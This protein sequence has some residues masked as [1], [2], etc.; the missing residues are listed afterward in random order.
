MSQGPLG[1][2]LWLICLLL[3]LWSV[4]EGARQAGAELIVEYGNTIQILTLIF[5]AVLGAMVHDVT[6]GNP[7][8]TVKDWRVP[9]FFGAMLLPFALE[10]FRRRI[11]ITDQQVTFISPWSRRLTVPWTEITGVEYQEWLQWHRLDLAG[12]RSVYLSDL[13]SGKEQF[14]GMVARRRSQQES[15]AEHAEHANQN[16]PAQL[17]Q[18]T[19]SEKEL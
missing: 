12:G 3:I 7:A 2:I 5:V 17:T 6:S 9:A 11:S 8:A 4:R 14:F 13:L 19:P 18:S 15:A 1:F 16:S 10:I